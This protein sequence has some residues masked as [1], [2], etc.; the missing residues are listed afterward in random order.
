MLKRTIRMG[1]LLVYNVIL[2]L[3]VCAFVNGVVSLD[4]E[5]MIDSTVLNVGEELHR[6]T[7]PLQMDRLNGLTSSTWYEVKILYPASIPSNFSTQLIR[8][9]LDVGHNWNRRLLTT[10]KTDFLVGNMFLEPAGV[11]AIPN[12]KE[13]ELVLFNTSS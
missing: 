2:L 5:N 1:Q 7:L 12:V 8:D 13:R 6:E 11:V 4:Q 9:K 3:Y 10:Q